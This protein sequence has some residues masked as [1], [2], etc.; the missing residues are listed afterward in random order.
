MGGCGTRLSLDALLQPAFTVR[1]KREGSEKGCPEESP[2][3]GLGVEPVEKVRNM[4]FNM[5]HPEWLQ[6]GVESVGRGE[7]REGRRLGRAARIVN[8]F[9]SHQTLH[10]IL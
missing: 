8:T 10:F 5:N 3:E 9:T 1:Q 6:R 4:R 7:A 2:W